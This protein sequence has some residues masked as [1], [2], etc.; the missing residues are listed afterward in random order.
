MIKK[1]LIFILIFFQINVYSDTKESFITKQSL[2]EQNLYEK[3]ID[4]FLNAI[5]IFNNSYALL[6]IEGK[7]D[8]DR[9]FYEV[10]THKSNEVKSIDINYINKLGE[11]PL[12]TAIEYKNNIVLKEL[13]KR[14]VNIN[15]KHP[16]IDKY[17]IH[18]AIYFENF[19]ALKMLL[20]YDKNFIN[21]KNDVDGWTPLEEAVLV[22]DIE[23]V[24]YLLDNG[25]DI[26][27]PDNLGNTSIDVAINTGRGEIVKLLRDTVKINRKKKHE[28]SR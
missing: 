12:M 24:K 5:K 9:D 25:A 16:S 3:K 22:G 1:Y 18:T 11:S 26:L 19:E 20:E 10:N 13:L 21:L 27:L 2:D 28:G 4:D 15:I 6:L 17:P 8:I 7:E 14:N 23:I